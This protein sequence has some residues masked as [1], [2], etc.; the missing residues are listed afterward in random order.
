VF[1][2][3]VSAFVLAR[4]STTSLNIIN[5]KQVLASII[6]IIAFVGVA[7]F[8][9]RDFKIHIGSQKNTQKASTRAVSV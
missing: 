8:F 2:S 6:I 3:I 1:F 7:L 9:V 5:R 4:A